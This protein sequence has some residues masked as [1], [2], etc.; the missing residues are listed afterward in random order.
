MNSLRLD[1]LTFYGLTYGLDYGYLVIY[2]D[3]FGGLHKM[4]IARGEWVNVY[5]DCE[6]LEYGGFFRKNFRHKCMR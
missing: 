3:G 2:G 6:Y 1:C 4:S 5:E